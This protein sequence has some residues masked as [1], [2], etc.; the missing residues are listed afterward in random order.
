MAVDEITY[1]GHKECSFIR[2]RKYLQVCILSS[3][4]TLTDFVLPFTL[5]S[6]CGAWWSVLDY[7][8]KALAFPPCDSLMCTS[9]VTSRR[10]QH[11][12]AVV[13]DFLESQHIKCS[14][15]KTSSWRK[16]SS[17]LSGKGACWADL[18]QGLNLECLHTRVTGMHKSS[19]LP[20]VAPGLAGT[21][22]GK[23]GF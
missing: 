3:V 1:V 7:L 15:N 11:I 19:I 5:L 22:W 21:C 23:A 17:F 8:H 13:T 20:T 12:S 10:N 14:P 6:Q 16:T 2:I 9:P 18:Q 4:F